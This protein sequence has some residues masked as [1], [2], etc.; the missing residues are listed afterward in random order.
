MGVPSL[1]EFKAQLSNAR[2]LEEA[3][4]SLKGLELSIKEHEEWSKLKEMFEEEIPTDSNIDFSL[5]MLS[6]VDK[7]KEEI[8]RQNSLPAT[9]DN[10]VVSITEQDVAEVIIDIRNEL[11]KLSPC[12]RFV[13]NSLLALKSF[14]RI[15]AEKSIEF[16][17]NNILSQL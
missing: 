3:K 2:K 1:D 8:A 15:I 10:L 12:K 13:K 9:T 14:G 5:E 16:G 6:A 4:V 11:E 7:Q 17:L